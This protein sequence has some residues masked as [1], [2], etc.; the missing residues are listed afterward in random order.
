MN[1]TAASC[2]VLPNTMFPLN[3][4]EGVQCTFV[5]ESAKMQWIIKSVVCFRAALCSELD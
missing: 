1:A 3:Y 2:P 4:G 5:F